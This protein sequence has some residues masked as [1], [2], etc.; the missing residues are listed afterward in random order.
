MSTPQ[1]VQQAFE[2]TIVA[3]FPPTMITGL[4]ALG[5]TR[6]LYLADDPALILYDSGGVFGTP[7][8]YA[9]RDQD[10]G[11]ALR[12][13]WIEG[14]THLLGHA[15]FKGFTATFL[16][17]A[18]L[19]ERALDI[20]QRGGAAPPLL[21]MRIQFTAEREALVATL[22]KRPDPTP[23]A[24]RAL[25][26]APQPRPARAMLSTIWQRASELP[27]ADLA[28]I[29]HLACG[30]V[31]AHV[32]L[33]EGRLWISKQNKADLADVPPGQLHVTDGTLE[34]S[35]MVAGAAVR[36]IDLP[37]HRAQALDAL[38]RAAGE[39]PSGPRGATDRATLQGGPESQV[40][41]VLTEDHLEVRARSGALLHA[42]DLRR[43]AVQGSTT[44]FLVVDADAGPYRLQPAT[45]RFQDLLVSHARV[46][47][48]A[49]R[50]T[51]EGPFLGLGANEVPIAVFSGPPLRIRG[52]DEPGRERLQIERSEDG[53]QLSVGAWTFAAAEPVVEAVANLLAAR[54]AADPALLEAELPALERDWVLYAVLGPLAETHRI[55]SETLGDPLRY[56]T[57][58]TERLTLL[59]LL[60]ERTP[61]LRRHSI[62]A[63]LELATFVHLAD[64]RLAEASGCA[65][66]PLNWDLDLLSDMTEALDRI[67][68]ELAQLDW[69]RKALTATAP[70]Y[71]RLA[72]NLGLSIINPL[73]LIGTGAEAV[74]I[75][76]IQRMTASVEAEGSERAAAAC[77][78][79]WMHLIRVVVPA[80]GHRLIQAYEPRRAWAS[81]LA[82]VTDPGGRAAI[83]LRFA[84]L[85]NFAR[86]ADAREGL[87]R[88]HA[89]Q[90]IHGWLDHVPDGW[91]KL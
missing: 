47:E 81:E 48:A 74:R 56:P 68:R 87:P 6:H 18:A 3:D 79:D 38:R 67:E 19:A 55:L 23:T 64:R 69:L 31:F 10:L 59:T 11:T 45:P 65:A 51:R 13:A 33:T 7:T 78:D 12:L 70:G 14:G 27:A 75:A 21:G 61:W 8:T 17:E 41:L 63:R 4:S 85:A 44:D 66:P 84:R 39:T 5:N 62:R 50:A 28:L 34:G 80:L 77:L 15:R 22:A 90:I 76:A 35:F 60:A 73:R 1:V 88:A 26:T 71:G 16:L 83:A 37:A 52:A 91:S 25:C 57:D 72:A 30:E 24:V 54:R 29:E 9:L 58:A 42:F 46:A 82:A 43:C 2:G 89:I 36:R 53:S 49:E 32:E 40:D 20:F 86:F